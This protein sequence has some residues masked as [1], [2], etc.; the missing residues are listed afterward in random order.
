[1]EVGSAAEVAGMVLTDTSSDPADILVAVAA[2]ALDGQ[3]TTAGVQATPEVLQVEQARS[4]IQ[5]L[6][7]LEAHSQ[8]SWASE[9]RYW[10]RESPED[11]ILMIFESS[12]SV[13]R[14]QTGTFRGLGRHKILHRGN[15]SLLMHTQGQQRE[16][17]PVL[18]VLRIGSWPLQRCQD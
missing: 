17:L 11:L 9:A 3:E 8:S 1:M 10:D 2:V 18:S 6:L 5:N 7:L 16:Q 14:Y 4:Q 12:R 13:T 15:R